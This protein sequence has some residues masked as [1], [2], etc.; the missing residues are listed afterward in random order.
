M[1]RDAEE[2]ARAGS[3]KE[4]GVG[5]GEGGQE[6]GEEETATGRGETGRGAKM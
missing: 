1:E 6:G 3:M 2:L 4:R 5:G